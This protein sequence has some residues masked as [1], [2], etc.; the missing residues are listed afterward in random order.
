M[1]HKPRKLRMDDL[2]LFNFRPVEWTVQTKAQFR[3]DQPEDVGR[4]SAKKRREKNNHQPSMHTYQQYSKFSSLV[5]L[6]HF[7]TG[8][9]LLFGRIPSIIASYVFSR[10]LSQLLILL[11]IWLLFVL[12]LLLW[13]LLF[14]TDYGGYQCT[15]CA[16]RDEEAE[17]SVP[18]HW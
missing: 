14:A 7:G 12:M 1:K 8:R 16:L 15:S 10:H 11:F 17:R 13:F 9:W 4:R 5:W 2:F 18:Q 6:L 3:Y